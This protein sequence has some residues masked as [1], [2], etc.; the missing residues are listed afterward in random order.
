MPA[1]ARPLSR[2]HPQA[3]GGTPG[4]RCL[5]EVDFSVSGPA[6]QAV[7]SPTDIHRVVYVACQLPLGLGFSATPEASVKIDNCE[8]PFRQN[9]KTSNWLLLKPRDSV[10]IQSVRKS[11][12]DDRENKPR[13]H[14]EIFAVIVFFVFAAELWCSTRR[15]C[16][17]VKWGGREHSRSWHWNL[18]A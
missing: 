11:S 10:G 7:A 9:T 17:L 14:R 15:Q 8:T 12:E 16:D 1:P 2:T 13:I 5:A 18:C 6:Q 3:F 4:Y